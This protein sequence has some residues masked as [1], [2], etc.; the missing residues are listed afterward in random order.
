M[1]NKLK[2]LRLLRIVAIIIV[3]AITIPALPVLAAPIISISPSSGVAG[4]RVKLSGSSFNSYIGDL[5]AVYFDNT[6]MP[7]SSVTIS[8]T[9]VFQ[10]TFTVPDSTLSGTHMVSIRGK[11]GVV[12]AESPFYVPIPEILL[13]KWSGTTGTEVKAFCKGFYAGKEVSIQ[14][15][16]S[17]LIEILA[18]PIASDIGEC[19]VQFTIPISSAG[20]HNIIASNERRTIAEAYFEVI[21]AQNLKPSTG[22]FGDKIE[23]TGTGYMS[24]SEVGV[25]L[26]GKRVAFAQTSER[27]SFDA[28]FYVPNVKAGKYAIEIEDSYRNKTWIDFTVDPK[29]TLSKP[30]GEVG[31]KL[32]VGGASFEVVSPVT[33]KYD[34][35][36]ISQI[37][38][39]T[40]GSFSYSFNVPVSAAGPH[41]I[42]VTDGFNTRQAAFTVDSD[43]P[44]A[45]KPTVPKRNSIVGGQVAFDWESV[46]D[47][48]EPVTYT[49]Q[50]AKR[51]D[52]VKPVFEK[53]N[54]SLSQ[55]L[56]N[57]EEALLPS[58][59]L[60]HYY[61]RIRATDSASNESNW[62]EPVIFQ[63]K[64]AYTLPDWAK[65]I[66]GI[67]GFLLVVVTFY[68]IRKAITGPKASIKKP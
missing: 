57:Q 26:Y 17:D 24:N 33:I 11:T 3:M 49:L 28:I 56:L 30:T 58:R 41:F 31:L 29:I 53:K 18:T 48:S 2:T 37:M 12:L 62:S 6:A 4:T 16:V 7:V 23:I 46:Y 42:T 25:T 52:F 27:G 38:T 39:D 55:Y 34:A 5:L 43:S 50:I 1:R 63:V 60:T 68:I 59:P 9:G 20:N 36:E 65:V 45:P 66:L 32:T 8:N 22:G 13:N 61:W 64:P 10:T 15:D 44:P 51:N 54:I 21:P 19:T 14:Y 67:T 40:D 35:E 47:P